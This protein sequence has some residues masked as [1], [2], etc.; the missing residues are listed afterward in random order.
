M[1][2]II[3]DGA[4]EA[5]PS[6]CVVRLRTTNWTDDNG[7]HTKRSLVWMRR[8]CKG[9]NWFKDDAQGGGAL[10]TINRIININECVDGVYEVVACDVSRDWESG[11][12]DDWNYRLIPL[13]RSDK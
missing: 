9:A 8:Q 1:N 7:I 10:A 5:E 3:R 12:V 11:L 13:T 6:K 2:G 4:A